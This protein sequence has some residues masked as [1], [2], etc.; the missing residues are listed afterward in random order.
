M[1]ATTVETLDVSICST[2]TNFSPA[3]AEASRANGRLSRGP[4]SEEGK[5][6]SRCNGCKGGLTGKGLVLPEAAAAEVARREAEYA[7]SFRPRD[8]VERELVRQMALGAWR[9]RELAVRI[10]EH[11]ARVNAA[12]FANWVEDERLA[13][14][15][16][17][18]RLGEDPEAAVAQLERTSSGCV[19][20]I[21]R[22]RLL[23]NGLS[24]AEDGGSG[25]RWNDADL[26]LV[27]NLLGRPAELRHL[28]EWPGRLESLR[29]RARSGSAEAVAALRQIIEGEV[30]R[31]ERRGEATWEELERPRL[32][33]W[34]AGLEIDLGAEGTR[35]RRYEAAA[36][37]L[38]RSAWRKLEQ[39]RKERGEPLMPGPECGFAPEPAAP[40]EPPAEPPP[41]RTPQATAP[42]AAPPEVMFPAPSL[43]GASEALLD[44]AVGGMP[45]IGL[46]FGQTSRDK[47]NPARGR[48]AKRGRDLLLSSLA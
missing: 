9:S 34:Q 7:R 4:V 33:D 41:A 6:I 29:A 5:A 3:R 17:G 12:K 24:T 47:T 14:I 18:R 32:R 36:D 45:Q 40:G 46:G 19:W 31:L 1:S 15:E 42:A 20:L 37:R 28:D 38:F 13:A 2:E 27:L 10:I 30:A 22:W 44:F 8:E 43:G 11:D 26:A 39:L 48:H 21:G 25:C 35:L 16:L 23:G